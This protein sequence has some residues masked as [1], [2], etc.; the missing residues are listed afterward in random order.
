M[1]LYQALRQAQLSASEAHIK[2]H[3]D[4]RSVSVKSAS[5]RPRITTQPSVAVLRDLAHLLRGIGNMIF[6]LCTPWPTWSISGDWIAETPATGKI[7]E[8][9]ATGREIL[10]FVDP[11]IMGAF[12]KTTGQAIVSAPNPYCTPSVLTHTDP[13][14]TRG[15]GSIR[16]SQI[17]RVRGVARLIFGPGF[18]QEWFATG[19][20]RG[21][22]AKLQELLGA[23][24]TSEGKKY[25]VL[26][27]ILF[28]EGSNAKKNIFLNPALIKVSNFII[29]SVHYAV[30]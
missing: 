10:A 18:E 22:V 2:A 30:H 12:M 4:A 13:Q 1:I 26:P 3:K 23:H 9:D 28:P 25:S 15:M 8:T 14:V 17:N 27:P 29:F 7:T 16:S 20:E 19:Y 21:S 5:T 6:N 24:M 11:E